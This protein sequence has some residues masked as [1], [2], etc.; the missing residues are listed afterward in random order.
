MGTVGFDTT[1]YI[2]HQGGISLP[3]AV[4]GATD[5]CTLPCKMAKVVLM[6]KWRSP[7]QGLG[8]RMQQM[9][10]IS[11]PDDRSGR[12]QDIHWYDGALGQFLTYTLGAIA[13]A[14]LFD[15]ACRAIL[16]LTAAIAAGGFA[17]LIDWLRTHVHRQGASKSTRDILIAARDRPVDAEAFVNHLD[18]RNRG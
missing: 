14:Q 1:E 17:P 11:L 7:A 13:A 3:K 4:A 2:P 18:R 12:L 10:G 15:A 9:V 8:A 5:H 16:G 6:P